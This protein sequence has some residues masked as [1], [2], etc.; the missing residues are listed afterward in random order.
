MAERLF[1]LWVS[2][3]GHYA[4][5]IAPQVTRMV[6]SIRVSEAEDSKTPGQPINYFYGVQNFGI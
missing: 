5:M 6:T 2:S 4:N 3:P 1:D